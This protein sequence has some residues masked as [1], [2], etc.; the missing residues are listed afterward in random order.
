ML[1]DF[2]QFG[3]IFCRACHATDVQPM[4]ASR[5]GFEAFMRGLLGELVGLKR[6]LLCLPSCSSC[7]LV[8]ATLTLSTLHLSC[9][10]LSSLHSSTQWHVVSPLTLLRTLRAKNRSVDPHCAVGMKLR[11]PLHT[12]NQGPVEG[13]F[14]RDKKGT[15]TQTFWSDIFRWGRG[16]PREGVGAKK[17]GMSLE[18]REIKFF[19]GDI[20]GFCRD[21]PEVPEKFEKKKFV[22]NSRPLV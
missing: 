16:L 20:P 21:I 14:I 19:G 11:C 3:R 22:F 13:G 18:T 1:G 5:K 15:Q 17:F 9:Y 6:L 7:S 8:S 4:E 12:M 2:S 10:A